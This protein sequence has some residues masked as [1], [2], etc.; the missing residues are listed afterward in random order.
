M[1]GRGGGM[2]GSWCTC[3]IQ[4]T[5]GYPF[6][7]NSF[8]GLNSGPW[9]STVKASTLW[10]TQP[11]LKQS[12]QAQEGPWHQ[13]P[14]C[15]HQS[16]T[17]RLKWADGFTLWRSKSYVEHL[18]H[19]AWLYGYRW[20]RGST[21]LTQASFKRGNWPDS[22]ASIQCVSYF[23]LTRI[24]CK[25]VIF[26]WIICKEHSSGYVRRNRAESCSP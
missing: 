23:R 1:L 15:V 4:G 21:K 12:F 13:S 3:E 25:E 9:P 22:V 2:H 24:Q 19:H 7:P 8:W 5:F 18:S 11:A 14:Q 26:K 20:V 10:A 16:H 17:G 6:T